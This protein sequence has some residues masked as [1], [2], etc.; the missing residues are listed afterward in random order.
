VQRL[1]S[2]QQLH[3]SNQVGCHLALPL[4]AHPSISYSLHLHSVNIPLTTLSIT[5]ITTLPLELYSDRRTLLLTF[6]SLHL[7]LR[8][9]T[10]LFR[11]LLPSSCLATPPPP[12]PASLNS[13]EA[14]STSGWAKQPPPLQRLNHPCPRCCNTTTPQP[15]H[16]PQPTTHTP[17]QSTCSQPP[18]TEEEARRTSSSLHLSRHRSTRT[19]C[20]TTTCSRRHCLTS[21]CTAH[22][23]H[24][25]LPPHW[26]P[27]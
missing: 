6:V 4:P 14:G 23:Y 19:L 8:R 10:Q 24:S 17:L 16:S 5:P 27:Q 12:M 22:L 13:P 25:T 2:N 21:P 1:H 18:S 20:L 3:T 7:H 26:L 9:P 11:P 15:H